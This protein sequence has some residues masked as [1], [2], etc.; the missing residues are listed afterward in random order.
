MLGDKAERYKD[1][2]DVEPARG[3]E[4]PHRRGNVWLAMVT[5]SLSA[6]RVRLWALSTANE[7]KSAPHLLDFW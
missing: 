6:S 3:E 5:V 7:P 1:E 2:E 4:P